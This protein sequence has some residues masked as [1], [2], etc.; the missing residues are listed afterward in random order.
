MAT[1]TVPMPGSGSNVSKSG[2]MRLIPMMMPSTG[3]AAIRRVAYRGN[4]GVF[5]WDKDGR[6]GNIADGCRFI[7]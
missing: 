5:K 2:A 3:N 6:A 1:M 7:G 4:A